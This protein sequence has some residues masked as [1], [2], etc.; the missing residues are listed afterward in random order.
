MSSLGLSFDQFLKQAPSFDR[1]DEVDNYVRLYRDD[2]LLL[3]F[4]SK[5]MDDKVVRTIDVVSSKVP[6]IGGIRVGMPLSAVTKTFSK[7]ELSIDLDEG[8][9]EY[10]VPSPLQKVASDG[11]PD[12]VTLLY[13]NSMDGRPLGT[14]MEN[15]YPTAKFRKEGAVRS[16]SFYKWNH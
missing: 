10:L 15:D 9:V 16:I 5:G 13:V 3:A 1:Q 8:E 2:E 12:I 4:S 11:R 14:G 6:V 7:V